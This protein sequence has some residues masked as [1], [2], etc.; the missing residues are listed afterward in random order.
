MN[1]IRLN[2]LLFCTLPC[3]EFPIHLHPVERINMHLLLSHLLLLRCLVRS[4]RCFSFFISTKFC[5]LCGL[6]DFET[7]AMR[8]CIFNISMVQSLNMFPFWFV[9]YSFFSTDFDCQKFSVCT[10]YSHSSLVV[11]ENMRT[12]TTAPRSLHWNER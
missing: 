12:T 2:T 11:Q 5:V 10:K 6:F 9:Q 4:C 8:W 1:F 3:S 7:S